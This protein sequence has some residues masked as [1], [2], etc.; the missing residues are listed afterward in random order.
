MLLGRLFRLDEKA[1]SRQH[2]SDQSSPT[3]VE[4][5]KELIA[6]R[7]TGNGRQFVPAVVVIGRTGGHRHRR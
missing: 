6:G 3:A 4:K 2:L 7:D 1:E 5:L